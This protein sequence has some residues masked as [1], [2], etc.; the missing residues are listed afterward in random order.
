V[1]TTEDRGLKI[2]DSGS[3]ADES[4]SSILYPPSSIPSELRR[5]LKQKLPEYMVPAALVILESLPLTPSGKIDRRALPVPAGIRPQL[6]TDYVA[7]QT[8]VQRTIAAV[9]RE[10]LGLKRVGLHDNFFDLGGHS[11][12]LVQVYGM[13]HDRFK[14]E[15]SVTDLFKFPT[16]KALADFISQERDA[17]HDG[18]Q[19]EV[20]AKRRQSALLRQ[21]QRRQ[22]ISKTGV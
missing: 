17:E 11:L 22:A 15:M 4:L 8:A 13:L 3:V 21:K 12:L 9:W 2:E 7:P 14:R 1:P 20:W 19:I 10:V 5:F 18:Q 16:V 6:E